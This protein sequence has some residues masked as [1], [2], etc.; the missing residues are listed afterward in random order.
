VSKTNILLMVADDIKIRLILAI[1]F[2]WTGDFFTSGRENI[3]VSLKI[4]SDSASMTVASRWARWHA[5]EAYCM[6]DPKP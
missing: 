1:F 5:L 3:A 6:V 4:R 2:N